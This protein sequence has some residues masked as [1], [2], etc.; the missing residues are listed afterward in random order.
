MKIQ[1]F[2]YAYGRNTYTQKRKTKEVEDLKPCP[3]CGARA[4]V[5]QEPLSS[6]K[7]NGCKEEYLCSIVHMSSNCIMS[8]RSIY[9]G[10][11]SDDTTKIEK[12][13]EYWNKRAGED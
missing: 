10:T 5:A 9:I 1:Y 13:I 6:D 12:F 11:M 2:E 7:L 8:G 4:I 3:F